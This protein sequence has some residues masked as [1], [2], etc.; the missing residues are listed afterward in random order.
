MWEW[1]PYEVMGA[2]YSK[3]ARKDDDVDDSPYSIEIN[4]KLL[5]SNFNILKILSYHDKGDH[6][7]NLDVYKTHMYLRKASPM[8]K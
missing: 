8:M 1:M 6:K 4:T 7:E 2:R 5:P 3:P